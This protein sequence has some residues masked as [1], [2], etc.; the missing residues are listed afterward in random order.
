[1]MPLSKTRQV[2]LTLFLL[3]FSYGAHAYDPSAPW[4]IAPPKGTA[5][6]LLSGYDSRTGEYK[7]RCVKPVKSK[8]LGVDEDG[9]T[10]YRLV[11]SMTETT[12]DRNLDVSV[13]LKVNLGF[14]GGHAKVDTSFEDKFRKKVEST[15]AYLSF[16]DLERP[17][18]ALPNAKYELNKKGREAYKAMLNGKPNVFTERCGDTLVVGKHYGRRFAGAGFVENTDEFKGKSRRYHAE[19]GARYLLSKLEG[20]VDLSESETKRAKKLKLKINYTTSGTYTGETATTINE[21][22]NVFKKFSTEKGTTSLQ[23]LY[24][25]SFFDVVK[26]PASKGFGMPRKQAKDVLRIIDGLAMLK[27]ARNAAYSDIAY[28]KRINEIRNKASASASALGVN[29]EFPKGLDVA[30]REAT[31]HALNREYS[32]LLGKLREQK[33][34]TQKFAR[35]CESLLNRVKEHSK[36]T[37]YDPKQKARWLNSFL[38]KAYASDT[39]CKKGFS[40]SKKDG[41]RICRKCA[42]AKEPQFFKGREGQ[43]GYIADKRKKKSHQRL[44]THDL[45][46]NAKDKPVA[47]YPDRCAKPNK[48]CGL[49]VA[50]RLCKSKGLGKAKAFE[51]WDWRPGNS[52]HH[53]KFITRFNNNK[54]CKENPNDFTPL[55]C[56]TF[57]YIDCTVPT[58]TNG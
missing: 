47:V 18:F 44:W 16:V 13:S 31:Y 29:A 51:I 34:C 55:K 24:M 41:T 19:L 6:Q 7:E 33:G 14:A 28:A 4:R 17:I 25:L 22:N 21:L 53:K 20:S 49:E 38:E 15:G 30:A 11:S 12:K 8:P 54:Q 58:R 42:V 32:Y 26:E 46:L 35:Q 56:R 5:L 45:R 39:P 1:M 52:I 40:I 23:Y 48:K 3:L 37:D 36:A 9:V 27:T 57:K 2:L 10:N 50:N 43:C